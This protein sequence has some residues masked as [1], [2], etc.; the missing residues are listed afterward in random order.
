MPRAWGKINDG[1]PFGL[2]AWDYARALSRAGLGEVELCLVWRVIE[3]TWGAAT[4]EAGR[5]SKPQPWLCPVRPL[6]REMGVSFT[7]LARAKDSLIRRRLLIE[8][9]AGLLPNKNVDQWQPLTS[10]AVVYARAAQRKAITND[11][12]AR[13]LQREHPRSLERE[14]RVLSKENTVLSEENMHVL[15]EENSA[16]S[17]KRT[18]PYKE[19]AEEDLRKNLIPE[20]S[21]SASDEE[22]LG[23]KPEDLGNDPEE[24]KR[25]AVW[26]STYG[27]HFDAYVRAQSRNFRI[28]WIEAA[29]LKAIGAG[30]KN[31]NYCTPIL[32]QWHVDG[33]PPA[34]RGPA[35][36]VAAPMT[37]QQER[38]AKRK[39]DIAL[40]KR[41]LAEGKLHV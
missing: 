6:A 41:L 7:S 17:S 23:G 21:S 10:E 39:A 15:V 22:P 28:G 25:V 33:G 12:P 13:S 19:R 1:Q 11:A 30:V 40:A 3:E 5:E 8:S 16:F 38:D 36:T 31:P 29:I 4:L 35:S 24:V 32:Q 18:V 27:T 20:S 26:A 34:A 9:K 2:I 37:R 14:Q